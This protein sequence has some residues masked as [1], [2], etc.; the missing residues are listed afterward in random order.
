MS[1]NYQRLTFQER[2]IIEKNIALG[3]NPSQIAALLSRNKSSVYRD[4]KRCKVGLYTAIHATFDSVYKASDRKTGKSKMNLN[5]EL[6]Q[7]VT[8]KL[9]LF[10]SPQQIHM[11]IKEDFP[12]DKSMR[13]A[14]ETIYFYIYIHAKP[15]LKATLIEHLRQKRKYRGNTRR[16]KD[17][18][19]TI[20]DKIS[21]DERPLEVIGRQVP[22]HWE[23]DLIMGKDRQSAIGTLN[24]R[25]TRTV[26]LV[27]L[28]ARDAASVRKAFEKEFKSIPSQMKKTLTYDNGTEM[29]Q[30]KLFSK[31]TKIKVYFAHPY[32]P[33]ERPTNE[34]S[35]GLLRDYFPKGTDLS[36]ISKKRLKEVQN[37]LN[38]RPRKVLNW[39]TPKDVFDEYIINNIDKKTA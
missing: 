13:I 5:K 24:E 20:A 26:I 32:S 31:N 23:G 39:R 16:G 27:H 18:R 7:Y 36:N 1:K 28:K 25:T 35:N 3:L 10:W 14:V 21:I 29:A 9:Q 38:E 37:Q 17:K 8:E 22:G 34:N 2:I 19:T 15:E 12:N 6:Y 30:H 33:W 11:K 4:I